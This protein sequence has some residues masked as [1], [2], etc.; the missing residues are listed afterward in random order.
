MSTRTASSK[1][2]LIAILLAGSFACAANT[3]YHGVP[4]G[5]LSDTQLVEEL[6]SAAKGYGVELNRSAYLMAVR[7]EPA[8]VLTSSSTAMVGSVN[9]TYNAYTMP[10]GYGTSTYGSVSGV[11]SGTANTSYHYT[12]ANAMAEL[13][14]SIAAAISRSKRE[15]YR[16]RALEVLKE[17]NRRVTE[18]RAATERVIVNFFED[19]PELENRRTLVAAVAPWAAAESGT[20]ARATLNGTKEIIDSLPRGDGV[21]GDWYGAFSQTTTTANGQV[22]AFNEF[23]RLTLDQT[24]NAFTGTGELGSGEKLEL[25]GTVNGSRITAEVANT[26]SAINVTMSGIDTPDQITGEFSGFGAGTRMKGT[27]TLLR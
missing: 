21:T 26:T 1:T 23:V 19:N 3:V 27:F 15:K 10:T 14:N 13:G 16:R 24:G 20:T 5:Q 4:V 17:Y 22:Y 7:P 18:R 6:Y 8:Y 9:A 2:F 12:D 25:S 11:A